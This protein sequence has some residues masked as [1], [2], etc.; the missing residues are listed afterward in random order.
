MRHLDEC[1]R[2]AGRHYEDWGKRISNHRQPFFN[3]AGKV[4]FVARLFS[5]VDYGGIWSN[6]SGQ[7]TPIA[8]MGNSGPGPNL[9]DG[10]KIRLLLWPRRFQ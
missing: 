1:R 10:K 4:T 9:P 5:S 8:R 2:V 3:N 7:V 6:V